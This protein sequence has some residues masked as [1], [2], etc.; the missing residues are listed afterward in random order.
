[1][2]GES[3]GTGRDIVMTQ[4]DINEIQL[5]KGAIAAGLD[6]LLRKWGASRQDLRT[7]FL[8][9]AFGNYIN[10]ES[11]RRIGLLN[12]SRETVRPAGNTALLGAKLAL[13]SVG[14]HNGAYPQVLARIQHV[15]LKEDPE[16][17]DAYVEQMG[18]PAA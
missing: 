11:A 9:G 16:F 7:V 14:D 12:F 2:P 6:L 17:Q 10:Y 4:Q 8:A 1:M 13:F 5:A 18:F 3:T 15:S